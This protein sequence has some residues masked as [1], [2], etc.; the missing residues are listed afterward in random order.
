MLLSSLSKK[1]MLSANKADREYFT[2]FVESNNCYF[3]LIKSGDHES[4]KN[5]YT[6]QNVLYLYVKSL[7]TG[8]TLV[9]DF[10]SNSSNV[11]FMFELV[12]ELKGY[13]RNQRYFN[14][15]LDCNMDN[16]IDVQVVHFYY[17]N[18]DMRMY[19]DYLGLFERLNKAKQYVNAVYLKDSKQKADSV[20]YKHYVKPVIL[21]GLE[22]DLFNY[23]DKELKLFQ[24]T[25]LTDVLK[26]F[27]KHI[28][29]LHK[30]ELN[31]IKVGDSILHQNYNFFTAT[32]RPSNAY[33][34]NFNAMSKKTGI[35]NEVTSRFDEGS[36]VEFDYH[37]SH[38][39]ILMDIID[40]QF[41]P[42][43]GDLYTYLSEELGVTDTMSRDEIKAEVFSIM[44]DEERFGQHDHIEYFRRVHE[45]AEEMRKDT[46]NIKTKIFERQVQV[47]KREGK[48]EEYYANR[49]QHKKHKKHHFGAFL[50]YYIQAHETE[51]NLTT[52]NKVINYINDNNLEMKMIL[53]VYDSLAFDVPENEIYHLSNIK[54]IIE[55]EGKFQISSS[56]GPSYGEMVD[57]NP[58]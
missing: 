15:V 45:F 9:I 40:Y 58:Q 11:E 17:S 14:Q 44:Y 34:M 21:L 12:S 50:N 23:F 54:S 5:H 18:E 30:T 10:E 43:T 7:D 2:K 49:T 47:Y 48:P 8:E 28:N 24:V 32:S 38:L 55:C 46:D 51:R 16:L 42:N 29:M 1:T 53:Y 3:S 57:F 33:K 36:I 52:I 31:G 39:Q 6:K 20:N 27:N 22:D 56:K 4:K 13:C 35:R 37:A 25:I 26:D 19:N 41:P